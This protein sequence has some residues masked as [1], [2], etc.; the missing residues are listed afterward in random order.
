MLKPHTELRRRR[1]R[2]KLSW[3]PCPASC[4]VEQ[5]NTVLHFGELA[6]CACIQELWF[7]TKTW[8]WGR[9]LFMQSW[10]QCMSTVG[11]GSRPSPAVLSMWPW[12]NMF[13]S[14]FSYV[15]FCNPTH[16]TETSARW[17]IPNSKPPGRIITMGQ[18][19]TLS[20]S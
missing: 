3:W 11:K 15:L 10:G 18:S 9:T 2:N 4:K 20:R 7:V 12:E 8:G 6:K 19:E 13:T 14:K 1:R 5:M 16:K 17:G